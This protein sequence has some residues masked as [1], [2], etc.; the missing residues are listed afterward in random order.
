[1]WQTA[2]MNLFIPFFIQYLF[3]VFYVPGMVLGI[4]SLF[5]TAYSPCPVAFRALLPAFPY[6]E[7]GRR[8]GQ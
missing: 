7:Q 2:S 1:M 4:H 5:K 8:E 3:S 6:F